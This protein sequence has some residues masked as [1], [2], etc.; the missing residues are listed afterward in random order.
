M[1]SVDQYSFSLALDHVKNGGR[2]T[3][4]GWNGPN[5]YVYIHRS[6]DDDHLDFLVMYNAQGK[7]VPWLAS[8]GD[9][10]AND[11]I[12]IIPKVN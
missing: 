11:W 3:R 5:Q 12:L 6:T 2:I 4:A 8:Q 7:H 1:K 9:L 10:L